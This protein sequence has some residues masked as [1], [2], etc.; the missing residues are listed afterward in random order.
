MAFVIDA[1]IVAAL[2]FGEEGGRRVA[3]AMGELESA[4]AFA[5]SIFFFEVRNILVVNERRGRITWEQSASFLRLLARLPIRLA[6]TPE[7]EDVVTLA[8]ARNLTVYDA[9]YLELAKR[10]GMPLA[11]LDHDLE[12]AAI[13]ENVALLGA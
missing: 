1:S 4:A 10:E 2:A 9:A 3:S 7:N 5:P 8:R 6:P 12:Q 11:T 13:A